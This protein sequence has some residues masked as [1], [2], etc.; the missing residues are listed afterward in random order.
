LI[1]LVG[2]NWWPLYRFDR[3]SN[4]LLYPT[5]ATSGFAPRLA[6]ADAHRA[7]HSTARS[8]TFLTLAGCQLRRALSQYKRVERVSDGPIFPAVAAAAIF[9]ASA[10]QFLQAPGDERQ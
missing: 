7:P 4:R 8:S 9:V 3:F 1:D 2:D 5:P 10:H 6:Q